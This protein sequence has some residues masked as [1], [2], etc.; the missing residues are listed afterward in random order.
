ML[1]CWTSCLGRGGCSCKGGGGPEVK[2]QVDALGLGM[3]FTD[4]GPKGPNPRLILIIR[5]RLRRG[6]DKGAGRRV[7]ARKAVHG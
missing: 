1:G 4:D 7:G 5:E 6:R 2:V 3:P